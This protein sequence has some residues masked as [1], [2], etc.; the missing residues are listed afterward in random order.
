MCNMKRQ[1]KRKTFFYLEIIV[2]EINKMGYNK[3]MK[4][5]TI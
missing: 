5:G 4:G 3:S 1:R 2:D